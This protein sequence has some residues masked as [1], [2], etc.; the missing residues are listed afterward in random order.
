MLLAV[1]EVWP[2]EKPILLRLSAEEY[3]KEGNHI[4][5]TFEIVNLVKKYVDCINVSTGGVVSTPI[6]P[7]PGYQVPF[8]EAIKKTCQIKTIAGGLI[9]N[10]QMIEEVLQNNRA[11]YVYLGRAL[12]RQPYFVLEAAKSLEV[13]IIPKSLERGFM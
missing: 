6:T 3:S 13:D 1:K 7:Y 12:L 11:D 10:Y 5:E 8:S 9:T 4:E 2:S